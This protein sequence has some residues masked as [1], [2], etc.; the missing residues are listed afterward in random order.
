M[1]DNNFFCRKN[2]TP[3]ELMWGKGLSGCTNRIEYTV[4]NI[5][6]NQSFFSEYRYSPMFFY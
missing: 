4:N 3:N 5:A 2:S 1:G 6:K